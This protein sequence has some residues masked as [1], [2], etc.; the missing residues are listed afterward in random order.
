MKTKLFIFVF[1][2][3]IIHLSC[4]RDRYTN[5]IGTWQTAYGEKDAQ[6]ISRIQFMELDNFYIAGIEYT[7]GL[8]RQKL[9]FYVCEKNNG[10]LII[11]PDKYF[12]ENNV[13]DL[14]LTKPTKV[15]FDE[16]FKKLYLTNL[17]F[18]SCPNNIFQFAGGK[19]QV[20]N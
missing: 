8:R 16:E 13:H 20:M 7:H 14:F 1:L 12:A 18:E 10:S 9:Y 6:L 19:L 5:F 2:F 3:L 15:Y 17:V 11:K 4:Q